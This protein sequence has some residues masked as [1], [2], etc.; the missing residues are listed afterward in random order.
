[1]G[2]MH[3][4]KAHIFSIK[5]PQRL[6]STYRFDKVMNDYVFTLGKLLIREKHIES[7]SIRQNGMKCK[8]GTITIIVAVAIIHGI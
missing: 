8:Y 7:L 2:I 5:W 4:F 6:D 3:S 1:M